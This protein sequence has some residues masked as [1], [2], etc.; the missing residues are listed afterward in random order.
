MKDE[1]RQGRRSPGG[2]GCT[3]LSTAA[4]CSK[5]DQSVSFLRPVTIIKVDVY[6]SCYLFGQLIDG[7]VEVTGTRGQPSR[8]A[9]RKLESF[10]REQRQLEHQPSRKR[11][12][13]GNNL[14]H[15]AQRHGYRSKSHQY[16]MDSLLSG[17]VNVCGQ[18]L[19]ISFQVFQ[20]TTLPLREPAEDV[21]RFS[22]SLDG[23]RNQ[24]A[25]CRSIKCLY[26]VFCEEPTI[27]S[28]RLFSP[29]MFLACFRLLCDLS[30]TSGKTSLMNCV[31]SGRHE[32]VI[33]DRKR[34]HDVV[35]VMRNKNARDT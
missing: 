4:A 1:F 15:P 7:Y 21:L 32:S 10:P 28:A 35:V 6:S 5:L 11:S 14:A 19:Y 16:R 24:S 27:H 26:S 3:A 17:G 9:M 29:T 34:A 25:C 22:I 13:V 31:R 2:F 33:A 8:L 18:C 30:Q 23:V 20:I 12:D